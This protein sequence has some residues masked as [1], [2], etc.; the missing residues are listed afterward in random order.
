MEW[1]GGS[2]RVQVDKVKWHLVVAGV[3]RG[4]IRKWEMVYRYGPS[5]PQSVACSLHLLLVN[6]PFGALDF[7]VS[8][9]FYE[10]FVIFV[11]TG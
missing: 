3:T 10:F 9:T 5:G 4:E 8:A 6:K 2:L 11:P 1:N 7:G